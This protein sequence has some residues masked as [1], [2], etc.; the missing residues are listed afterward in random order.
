MYAS[1]LWSVCSHS[2]VQGERTPLMLTAQWNKS[3]QAA[4]IGERL[5]EGKADVNAGDM[6]RAWEVMVRGFIYI[7]G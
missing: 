4:A 1:H 3:A 6:V 7:Y 5:L 2:I